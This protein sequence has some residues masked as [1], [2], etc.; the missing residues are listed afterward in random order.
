MRMELDGTPAGERLLSP[1][2]LDMMPCP[3]WIHDAGTLRLLYFNRAAQER[4]GLSPEDLHSSLLRI[5]PEWQDPPPVP[6]QGATPLPRRLSSRGGGVLEVDLSARRI[7]YGDRKAWLVVANDLVDRKQA[8]RALAEAEARYQSIFLNAVE[9]IFQTTPEGRYLDANPAL[10]RIY[11]YDSPAHLIEAITDIRRQLYVDP[12]RRDTFV[13]LMQEHGSVEGFESQVIRR[14]GSHVWISE[15]VRAVRNAEGELLYY[16]GTVIDITQRKL[17]E[18]RLRHEALHDKLTGLPNRSLFMGRTAEALRE[19]REGSLCGLL[20]IDFDKFKLINDSLGHLAGDQFLV[21]ASRRLAGAV[22]PGDLVARL[23][24][25]EFAVLLPGVPSLEAVRDVAERIG[26]I[27]QQPFEVG[28]RR[29]FVTASVGIALGDPS[30]SRPEDLLRDADVA[31]YRAKER[32]R[33]RQELFDAGMR[34][35]AVERLQL[36]SD[37]RAALERGQF[38]LHYQPLVHLETGRTL[39][40]EALLRWNHPTRGLLY[41]GDFLSV[42]E[43]CGVILDLGAWV[44]KAACA[45][46]SRWQRLTGHTPPISVN[47]STHQLM[48]PEFTASVSRLLKDAGLSGDRLKIEITETVLMDNPEGIARGLAELREQGVGICLDDFG[49]GFSSLSYLHRFPID[50]LKIDRTFVARI[51]S[52]G[53]GD[54]ILRAIINLAHTLGLDTVA[55]GVETPAQAL[56]L[57]SLGCALAQGHHFSPP[58]PAELAESFR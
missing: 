1:A 30:Y 12:S 44:L 11:G 34:E 26:Q 46:A 40:F 3:V 57:R 39:A 14:D 49:T 25:D 6:I 20:F 8:A 55:E 16:E 45:Q 33:A 35:D 42:A 28:G 27:L 56:E 47:L 18:E 36:E 37:L 48:E 4:L 31:M 38:V 54:A 50:Q 41:P 29:L 17:A 23:G 13:K 10:A 2:V 53:S 51:G 58:L 24:G 9:G 22:R 21:A 32:G 5:L 52:D 19:A 43:E 7:A 15:S